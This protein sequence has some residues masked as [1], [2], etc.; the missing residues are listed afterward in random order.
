MKKISI[1]KKVFKS[2]VEPRNNLDDR[3]YYYLQKNAVG[4]S[5]RVKS[6]ILMDKFNIN[7]NKTLRSHIESIRDNMDYQ[8]IVCSEAGKH[9]GYW[10]ATNKEEVYDT[11]EHLYKR[12][13]KMLKT[14]SR[15]RKKARLN[16]QMTLKLNKSEKEIYK[17][18]MEE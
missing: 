16:R 1:F 9:G 17:S 18:I 12:S 11:L 4:Y 14:Y 10:I 13:M 3:I 7:D 15:I 6:S 5:K 2:P 8:L